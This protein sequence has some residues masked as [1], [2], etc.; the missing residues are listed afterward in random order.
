MNRLHCRFRLKSLLCS[1]HADDMIKIPVVGMSGL[2]SHGRE[3]V[4]QLLGGDASEGR[5]VAFVHHAEH[6]GSREPFAFFFRLG[7]AE[8]RMENILYRCLAKGSGCL[9]SRHG[10]SREARNGRRYFFPILV[11]YSRVRG[12]TYCF[13]LLW[14]KTSI[15]KSLKH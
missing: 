6:V 8:G 2:E 7:T 5:G 11:R 15:R 13:A 9:Y 10:A 14:G 3:P 4:A 1:I 12:P